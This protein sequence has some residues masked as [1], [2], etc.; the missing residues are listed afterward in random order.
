MRAEVL[1]KFNFVKLSGSAYP[2]KTILSQI[3][4]QTI[5]SCQFQ[6]LTNGKEWELILCDEVTSVGHYNNRR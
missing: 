6:D 4:H 1:V 3:S 5:V 2:R